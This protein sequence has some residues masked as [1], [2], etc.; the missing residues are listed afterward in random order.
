MIALAIRY[1]F[2]QIDPCMNDTELA[3][4][5][6]YLAFQHSH[7]LGMQRCKHVHLI[8]GILSVFSTAVIEESVNRKLK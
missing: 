6:K 1:F 8:W 4:K 3:D 7:R 5:P 2:S